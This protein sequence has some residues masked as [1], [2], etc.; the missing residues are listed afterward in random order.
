MATRTELN[1]I[2]GITV[3]SG[4]IIMNSIF[5]PTDTVLFVRSSVF[6]TLPVS[7]CTVLGFIIIVI[8]III[9]PLLKVTTTTTICHWHNP[10]GRTVALGLTQPLIEMGNRNISLGVKDAGV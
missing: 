7:S 9:S 6:Y 2:K 4:T 5:K 8:I 3:H 1:H 10:S